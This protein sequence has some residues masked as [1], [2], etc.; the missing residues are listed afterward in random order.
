MRRGQSTLELCLVLVIAILALTA[1]WPLLRDAVAA[2]FRST[3]DTFSFGLQF[4]PGVTQCSENG[5]PVSC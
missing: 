5:V 4:E 2:R 3:A 1:M